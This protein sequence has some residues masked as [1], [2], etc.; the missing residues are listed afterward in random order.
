MSQIEM[1]FTALFFYI[2]LQEDLRSQLK[3][4]AA[5][6]EQLKDKLQRQEASQSAVSMASVNLS[7]L[8]KFIP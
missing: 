2:S 7:Q 8:G 1:D 4:Y 6:N 5:A 3:K